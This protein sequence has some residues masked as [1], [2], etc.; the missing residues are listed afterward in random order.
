MG[1]A[2]R[3][4]AEALAAWE[5]PEEIRRQAPADPW[6]LNPSLFRQRDAEEPP[7]DTPSRRR[8]LEVL[9]DG[10]TVLDVG[11]GAGGASL[12]LAPPA[13]LVVGVDEDPRMLEAFAAA[14]DERGV[15]HREV[16]GRWPDVAGDAP[17]AEVVM[18]HHVFYN[19]PDLAPFALALTEHAR[20][21]VVV[22][23]SERHPVAAT[24][25][26]WKEFWGIDRPEGPTAD[27]ALAV[28]A[29]AGLSPEVERDE[30]PAWRRSRDP[31]GMA[32][33]TRRLCLPPERQPEVERALARLGEPSTRRVVTLWWEGTGA[34]RPAGSG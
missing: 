18:S 33:L 10:G 14:A 19:V 16:H 2:E 13:G 12:P 5:I 29:E 31:Q 22:E 8:A 24:N 15:A 30:R 23:I 32:Y 9:P 27:D 25:P 4:W 3:R 21:R 26:L 34:L 17:V 1:D 7:P 11:V 28:L 20:R 6:Q